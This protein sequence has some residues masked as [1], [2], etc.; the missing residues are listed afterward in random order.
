MKQTLEISLG[1]KQ[2]WGDIETEMWSST[3][4]HDLKKNRFSIYSDLSIRLFKGF[5][6]NLHGGFSWIR[7]Q[8]FLRNEP[9]N[10]EDVL[11]R[12]YVLQTDYDYWGSVGFEYSFGSI[13][14]N[15]VNPRFGY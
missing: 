14:N 5:S 9:L 10:K 3:Y 12:R 7:D 13:Y 8:L 6:I 1:F 11:L 4:L 15:I 2:P